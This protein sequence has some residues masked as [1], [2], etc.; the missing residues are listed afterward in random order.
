MASLSIAASPIEWVGSQRF[1]CAKISGLKLAANELTLLLFDK[2]SKPN[3]EN[4]KKLHGPACKSA[5]G[6]R[7]A[8]GEGLE[9]LVDLP[10]ALVDD[11]DGKTGQAYFK[12]DFLNIPRR[13][14]VVTS[15]LVLSDYPVNGLVWILGHELGHGAYGHYGKKVAT[16]IAG[17]VAIGGAIRLG[18]GKGFLKK[19]IAA[20]VG[21][22]GVVAFPCGGALLSPQQELNADIFGVRVL[23]KLGHT[24]PSAKAITLKVLQPHKGDPEGACIGRGRKDFLDHNPHP[25]GISR[26]EAIGAME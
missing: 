17:G 25:T 21:T 18:F 1:D 14:V 4:L 13:Y 24:L 10:F 19:G 6:A 3:Q 9:W 16:Q 5:Y 12:R 20:A 7:E 23:Q 22:A 8:S 26:I 2:T 15:D 11:I